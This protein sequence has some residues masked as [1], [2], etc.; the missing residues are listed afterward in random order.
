MKKFPCLVLGLLSLLTGLAQTGSRK[1][2]GVW[3]SYLDDRITFE[4]L[5]LDADGTGLKCFGQT[6][7]GKDTLFVNQI[8]ALVITNWEERGD[9]I[10]INSRNRVS[11]KLNPAYAVRYLDS[12]KI[13]LTG[14]H[15]KLGFYP[16][17]L[18]RNLFARTVTY[19]RA[20]SIVGDY[21]VVAA[22]CIVGPNTF[23]FTSIDSQT[24][25]ATYK[26][27]DDLIPHIVSC[28]TAYK[29]TQHYRDPGYQ[30]IVPAAVRR[31]DYGFGNGIFYLRLNSP[32]GDTP[33]MSIVIYY[34]F[35][36]KYQSGRFADLRKDGGKPD[37]VRVN[38]RDIYR[39]INWEGKYSGEIFLANAISVSYYT[40]D[41]NLEGLLEKCIA[42][43]EYR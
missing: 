42:S 5:R 20:E 1:P 10:Y 34:D 30:L 11:Y 43:F 21:G 12:D 23:T 33:V 13:E 37:V 8:T 4:Y 38:N 29:Y 36:G 26:G 7:N 15:L 22:A 3:K 27:F 39:A 31:T 6:M 18:N 17:V 19:Q 25:M 24:C 28:G 35:D 2:V 16:S 41:K 32:E 9:F 14:E 40:K